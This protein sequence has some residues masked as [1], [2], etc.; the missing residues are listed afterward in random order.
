MVTR[1]ALRQTIFGGPMLGRIV[2]MAGAVALASG[3]FLWHGVGHASPALPDPQSVMTDPNQAR[4]DYVE[5]C[6]GCHGVAGDTV[7]AHLPELAG[8]VGWFMCTPEARAYL[9][10]LPNVA[11]SR[12]KDNAELADL[13]NYVVFV[14]GKGTAPAGTAPFTADEV[15]RERKLALTNM[16]LSAERLRLANTLVQQCHAPASIRQLYVTPDTGSAQ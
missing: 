6:G 15:A 3:V 1:S 14:L 12:I 16:N 11:H 5:N 4:I 7:P 9:I 8:R 10:R 2:A 13:M